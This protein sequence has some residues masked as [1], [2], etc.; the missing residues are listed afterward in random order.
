ME[1]RARCIHMLSRT[2]QHAMEGVMDWTE[3]PVI[4]TVPDRMSGAPVLR[5]SRVRPDDLLNNIEQTPEWMADAFNLSIEDVRAV[6]SFYH[7]H[8]SELAHTP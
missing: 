3:C 4:E 5:H 8:Q 2:S 6:L 1:L 7:Q